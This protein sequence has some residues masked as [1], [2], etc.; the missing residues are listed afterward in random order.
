MGSSMSAL[1]NEWASKNYHKMP[2]KIC[3]LYTLPP[4]GHSTHSA[5]TL[6]LKT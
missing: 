1:R 2:L 3:Q 6:R 5:L 4:R